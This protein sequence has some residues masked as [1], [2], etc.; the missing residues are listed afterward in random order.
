[1]NITDNIQPF[2]KLFELKEGLEPPYQGFADLDLT[3]RTFKHFV[4][5]QGV[6]P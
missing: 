6:E 5:P 2:F 1:M 3:D 4:E